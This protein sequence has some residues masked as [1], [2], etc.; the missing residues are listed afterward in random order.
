MRIA[1]LA[2]A[3]ALGGSTDLLIQVRD[4]LLQRG[5]TIQCIFGGGV[6]PMDPRCQDAL[7]FKSDA[8]SWRERMRAYVALVEGFQPDIAY[9]FAGYHEMDLFR[10]LRC[11]RVRHVS[12]LEQHG[13]ADIPFWLSEYCDYFEACTANTPDALAE[14][15]RYSGKP[16]FLLP[17]RMPQME[18]SFAKVELPSKI[19][20]TRRLEVAF[21]SRLERFQKRSHWLPEI[22]R[23]CDQLGVPLN[24]NI[25]GDGPEGPLLR[26]RLAKATHVTFHGW[27]DRGSLYRVLP[28]NDLFFLCSLW[29]GLP[30]SM[31]E[32]MRCG[33]ACVVPDIPAGI[34]WTISH[35]GGWLY[36]AK[37][38]RAAAMALAEAARD[39]DLLLEK[40]AEA[41]RLAVELFPPSLA[42]Q[43]YPKLE[44]EL[45]KLTFNGKVLDIATAPKLQSIRF[46]GLKQ[47]VAYVVEKGLNSPAWFFKKSAQLAKQSVGM[48]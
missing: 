23:H 33:V 36:Q 28:R 21:V 43:Y 17:Y 30:I 18:D 10:F 22:I 25:Y 39:R 27:M 2:H 6:S 32:A 48:R 35:G 38:P 12:T 20:G 3:P 11:V 15:E 13:F 34:H 41:L 45:E 40:R 44:A 1:L 9:A 8:R 5:H 19:D 26:R 42:E 16:S 47:R 14:V 46:S 31:V 4:F 29:E 24:W 37:S 7:I